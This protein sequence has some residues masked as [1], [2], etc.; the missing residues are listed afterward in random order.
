M[1]SN[2]YI[3]GDTVFPDNKGYHS[4]IHKISQN[5]STVQLMGKM[6]TSQSGHHQYKGIEE[7]SEQRAHLNQI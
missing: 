1:P 2:S 5:S 3:I 7:A 6:E 4:I